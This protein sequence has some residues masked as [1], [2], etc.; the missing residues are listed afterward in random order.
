MIT[1]TI[2]KQLTKNK[3]TWSD[4]TKDLKINSVTLWRWKNKKPISKKHLL[5][6]T[7]Y[8]NCTDSDLLTFK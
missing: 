8:F 7:Q 1:S 5:I 4:L 2:Q 3:K 6:L